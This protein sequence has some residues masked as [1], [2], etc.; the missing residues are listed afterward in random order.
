MNCIYCDEPI[1][2]TDLRGKHSLDVMH[3]ECSMRMVA[4]S[5]AHQRRQCWCFD[6]TKEGPEDDPNLSLRENAKLAC[7]EWH[8]DHVVTSE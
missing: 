2:P 5:V 4:G 7:R 8:M 1:L 3:Y 6:K